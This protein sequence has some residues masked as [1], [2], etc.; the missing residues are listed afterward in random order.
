MY[1]SAGNVVAKNMV[2]RE[3]WR[4]EMSGGVEGDDVVFEV[5]SKPGTDTPYNAKL[6]VWCHRGGETNI[7]VS[8]GHLMDNIP[9]GSLGGLVPD[10]ERLV[11]TRL[12]R[13]SPQIEQWVVGLNSDLYSPKTY[14]HEMLEAQVFYFQFM[15]AGEDRPITLVFPIDGLKQYRKRLEEN[16]GDSW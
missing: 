1:D 3:Q 15:P 9:Y 16:C 2:G 12:D 5:Q 14:L 13:E 11:K 4:T 7:I 6:K 10:S 8:T